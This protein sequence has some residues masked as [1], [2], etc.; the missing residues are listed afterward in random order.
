MLCWPCWALHLRM[1]EPWQQIRLTLKVP[2]TLA[3]TNGVRCQ[4]RIR[5]IWRRWPGMLGL[6]WK[7]W[8]LIITQVNLEESGTSALSPISRLLPWISS[9]QRNLGTWVLISIK[10]SSQNSSYIRLAQLILLKLDTEQIKDNEYPK[11]MQDFQISRPKKLPL[12]KV[13]YETT[14]FCSWRSKH[15][16]P[17]VHT[18]QI[19]WQ[20]LWLQY[21]SFLTFFLLLQDYSLDP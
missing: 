1:G 17:A 20:P 18:P 10:Y 15:D 3:L 11:P 5:L 4:C 9:T 14:S 21:V 19:L 12:S 7:C 13:V 16:Q 6:H 2:K 8:D